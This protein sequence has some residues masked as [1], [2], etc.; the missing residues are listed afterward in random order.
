MV[1]QTWLTYIYSPAAG[2]FFRS[3]EAREGEGKR[4]DKSV[5]SDVFRHHISQYHRRHH[6]HQM[7]PILFCFLRLLLR[8]LPY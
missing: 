5:S 1:C 4:F 2:G 6:L 8:S 3:R 7:T